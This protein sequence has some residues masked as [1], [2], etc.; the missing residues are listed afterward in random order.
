[1]V[2]G[3]DSEHF[4]PERPVTRAEFAKLLVCTFDL[5]P[6]SADAPRFIDVAEKDWYYQYVRTLTALGLIQG[7]GDGSF[8][9][10]RE[11]SRQDMAVIMYRLL[12]AEDF[13][14]SGEA[15][16]PA[17]G[18]ELSDYAVEAVG[19]LLAEGVVSGDTEGNFRGNE[20]ASRAQAAA[21]LYNCLRRTSGMK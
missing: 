18:T 13:H 15:A 1:M 4:E 17:D 11:I 2:T 20:P 10:G 7:M 16:V 21:M 19:R 3:V 9:A 6:S 5:I 12:E 8:G 14:F